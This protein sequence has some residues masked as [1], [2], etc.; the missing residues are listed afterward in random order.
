MIYYLTVSKKANIFIVFIAV[1]LAVLGVFAVL[2]FRYTVVIVNEAAGDGAREVVLLPEPVDETQKPEETPKPLNPTVKVRATS[3]GYLNV[4]DSATTQG[5]LLGKV[6][7]GTV[8]EY[9][10]KKSE[11]YRILVFEKDAQ[12]VWSCQRQV[13]NAEGKDAWVSGDY[14]DEVDRS[15]DLF[16]KA[17]G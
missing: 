7:P 11:W 4:R 12:D 1:A 2:K 10:E 3:A 5:K 6:L 17:G 9:T 8:C 16:Q 13:L 15:K 14:V